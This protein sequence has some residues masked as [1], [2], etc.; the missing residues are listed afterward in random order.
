MA[1]LSAGSPELQFEAGELE[2]A[3]TVDETFQLEEL[4]EA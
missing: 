1:M 2:V 4:R 3:A